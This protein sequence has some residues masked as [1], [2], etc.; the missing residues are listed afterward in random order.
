MKNMDVA[1]PSGS[2]EVELSQ[3]GDGLKLIAPRDQWLLLTG[4]EQVSTRHDYAVVSIVRGLRNVLMINVSECIG[5]PFPLRIRIP[6]R[7]EFGISAWELE[8]TVVMRLTWQATSG[9]TGG[10]K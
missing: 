2:M 3:K 8:A 5:E 9:P 4:L 1:E 10:P 6:P 7:Q